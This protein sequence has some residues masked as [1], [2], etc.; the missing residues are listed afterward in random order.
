MSL[1]NWDPNEAHSQID[2][3]HID[4]DEFIQLGHLEGVEHNCKN[5][6]EV[7]L[8][9]LEVLMKQGKN[10]WLQSCE[11]LP[12]ESITPLIYFFTVAEEQHSQLEAGNNSPVIA[13]NTLLKSRGEHLGKEDLVW[14]REHSSNR[15][16]PNGSVF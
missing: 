8:K 9:T 12:R 5:L 15:F 11:K 1:G 14:I 10:F 6:S 13:L 7:Q 4:L 2:V 3:N 16:L